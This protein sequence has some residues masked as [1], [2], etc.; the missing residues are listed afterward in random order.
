MRPNQ[1]AGI[2]GD[3]LSCFPFAL[4]CSL[5]TIGTNETTS[6]S[7]SILHTP[8]GVP[9]QQFEGEK[10]VLANGG[11]FR[12]T[13][14]LHALATRERKYFAGSEQCEKLELYA[15]VETCFF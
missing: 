7:D 6:D 12:A 14:L 3:E 5:T 4:Y 11:N 8:Q 10:K 15:D 13:H 2:S 9:P 1:V